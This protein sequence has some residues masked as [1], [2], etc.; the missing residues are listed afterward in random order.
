MLDSMVLT[1]AKGIVIEEGSI[2][3]GDQVTCGIQCL[4]LLCKLQG[5]P[6]NMDDL[7]STVPHKEE[8]ISMLDLKKTAENLGFICHGYEVDFEGLKQLQLPAIV[9]LKKTHYMLLLSI[10]PES[11]KVADPPSRL[12][13][14]SRKE[15]IEEWSGYI[16]TC[17]LDENVYGK[18]MLSKARE[19]VY[20]K[21]PL[22]DLSVSPSGK[23]YNHAFTVVNAS[24]KDV[25]ILSV[26]SSCGCTIAEL[27]TKHIRPGKNATVNVTL[28][29]AGR[30]G[31]FEG[32][33]IV[34]T[35]SVKYPVVVAE[36]KA[37]FKLY[38]GALAVFPENIVW[39]EILR[40]NCASRKIKVMRHGKDPL[41][42][43]RATCDVPHITVNVINGQNGS[44][45]SPEKSIRLEVSV[46]P[47]M[48]IG[49]FGGTLKIETDH[50]KYPTVQIPIK[51]TV[52]GDI[53]TVPRSLFINLDSANP[54]QRAIMLESQRGG[55][56]KVTNA[57]FNSTDFPGEVNYS[58]LTDSLWQ[59]RFL[60]DTLPPK[61][62]MQ[63]TIIVE[64]D[65]EDTS[66]ITI[67]ITI[68]QIH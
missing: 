68:V 3:P 28:H 18:T 5:V 54:I 10:E 42:F 24:N 7:L 22:W 14:I 57:K 66:R 41:N 16:L 51:G 27:S 53:K 12:L 35:N 55:R 67:P 50:S 26:N 49:T 25:E 15:F 8:R 29:T 23:T 32:R 44:N 36:I 37:K 45:P 62:I 63:T 6:A 64:T 1:N 38:Q 59:I 9:H 30:T 4:Y 43:I 46:D 60:I 11:V 31:P 65:A 61:P 13:E 40:G 48:A 33:I 17:E 19:S 20:I 21:N 58:K 52:I 34:K 47:D 2:I 56:F 39:A